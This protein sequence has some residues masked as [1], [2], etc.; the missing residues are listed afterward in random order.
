MPEASCEEA[1]DKRILE[2]QNQLLKER[3]KLLNSIFD[4]K[5]M[6]MA[7]F[8]R[9][10]PLPATEAERLL[11]VDKYGLADMEFPVPG[12]QTIFAFLFHV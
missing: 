12:E 1:K 3:V 7:H 4:E 2:L 9:Y 10:F 11:T 8:T 5:K 6:D